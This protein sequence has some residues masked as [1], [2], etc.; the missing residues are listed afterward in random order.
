[1][2]AR[3]TSPLL[4]SVLVFPLAKRGE[5]VRVLRNIPLFSSPVLK[6]DLFGD[7]SWTKMEHISGIFIQIGPETT[8]LLLFEI[9]NFEGWQVRGTVALIDG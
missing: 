9:G 4:S 8:K 7:Y 2:S 6:N 5:P 1:M 3:W